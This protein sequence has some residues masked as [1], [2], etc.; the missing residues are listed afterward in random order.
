[1]VAYRCPNL[2]TRFPDRRC[3]AL[4]LNAEFRGMIAIS[5]WRCNEVVV[6]RS[7]YVGTEGLDGMATVAV[8]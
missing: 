8:S 1:M 3:D 2:H 7:E 6:L 4:L 5:C